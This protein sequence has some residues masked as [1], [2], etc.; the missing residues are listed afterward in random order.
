MNNLP[1]IP[2]FI[3]GTYSMPFLEKLL[4]EEL[5]ELM[6]AFRSIESKWPTKGEMTKALKGNQKQKQKKKNRT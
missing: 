1:I 3:V 2:K 5:I 4:L 6:L